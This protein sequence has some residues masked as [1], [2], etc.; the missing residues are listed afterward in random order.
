MGFPFIFLVFH[1]NICQ[2]DIFIM[3]KFYISKVV[4]TL[5][6]RTVLIQPIS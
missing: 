6:K 2:M 3:V 5:I 4:Y 1:A